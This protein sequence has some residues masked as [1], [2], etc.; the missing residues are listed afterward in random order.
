MLQRVI[1]FLVNLP[2]IMKASVAAK[3]NHPSRQPC[4][5]HESKYLLQ[6]V[7]TT[8]LCEDDSVDEFMQVSEEKHVVHDWIVFLSLTAPWLSDRWKQEVH[9]AF[10]VTI[11]IAFCCLSS[12]K[13]HHVPS[14]PKNLEDVGCM[15]AVL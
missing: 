14:D 4:Q 1:T 3:S 13:V 8:E 5:D 6:W 11:H 2:I 7:M 10:H 15:R 12:P 9:A